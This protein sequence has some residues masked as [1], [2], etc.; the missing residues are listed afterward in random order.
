MECDVCYCIWTLRSENSCAG[1]E[2]LKYKYSS[3]EDDGG[4]IPSSDSDYN[5]QSDQGTL[6]IHAYDVLFETL[7][8]GTEF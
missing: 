5:A 2:K 7:C 3:E 1:K 8:S 6:L 4:A